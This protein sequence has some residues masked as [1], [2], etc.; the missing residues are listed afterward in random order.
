[1]PNK[2]KP[3]FANSDAIKNLTQGQQKLSLI[4]GDEEFEKPNIEEVE[5]DKSLQDTTPAYKK[6]HNVPIYD[7]QYEVLQ[8]ISTIEGI[9]ITDLARTAL[10]K[11]IIE[12][13][14]E[15]GT[16]KIE[17]MITIRKKIKRAKN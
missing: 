14:D 9:P 8:A 16:T 6:R 5:E 13:S 3:S 7:D 15:I 17:E 2:K 11:I 4:D 1:M 10:E 12:K